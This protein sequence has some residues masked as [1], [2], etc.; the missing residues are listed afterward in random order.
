MYKEIL[1]KNPRNVYQCEYCCSVIEGEH[2]KIALVQDNDFHSFRVH[3][4]CLEGQRDMCNICEY[5]NDC[6]TSVSE[7]FYEK[8]R[9]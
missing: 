4:E 3:P 6:Q 7:C 5:R 9:R 1:V 2:I 8:Y